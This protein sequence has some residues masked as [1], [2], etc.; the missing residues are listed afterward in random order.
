MSGSGAEYGHLK[1]SILNFPTVSEWTRHMEE[2][3]E[4]RTT[5]LRIHQ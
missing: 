3:G 4:T 2:A 5:T 1:D